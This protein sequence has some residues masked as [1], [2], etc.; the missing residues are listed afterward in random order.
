MRAV[1]L[2]DDQAVLRRL[3]REQPLER[4]DVDSIMAALFDIRRMVEEIH[5]LFFEE[6]N[7]EEE[8]A[9]S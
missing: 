8:T 5:A 1:A 6:E 9:P 2:F 3:K 4:R 7:G